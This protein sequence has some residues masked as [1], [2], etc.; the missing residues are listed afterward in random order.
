VVVEVEGS[1]IALSSEVADCI[2]VEEQG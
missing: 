2:L 1:D